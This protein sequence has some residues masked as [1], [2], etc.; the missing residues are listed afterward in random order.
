MM[1]NLRIVIDLI[2]AQCLPAWRGD[3]PTLADYALV[4]LIALLFAFACWQCARAFLIRDDAATERIKRAI[5]AQGRPH[6]D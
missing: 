6:A 2:A 4:T 5:L 3:A 1:E